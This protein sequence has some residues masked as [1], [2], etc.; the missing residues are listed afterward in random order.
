MDS[1]EP[2][3][4]PQP[5][6]MEGYPDDGSKLEQVTAAAAEAAAQQAAKPGPPQPAVAETGG[7]QPSKADDRFYCPYPGESG[8][9][10]GHRCFSLHSDPDLVL[11]ACI[12]RLQSLFC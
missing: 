7:L 2:Q 10:G 8:C 12:P 1:L 5:V 6:K 9:L 4:V 3:L 11:L